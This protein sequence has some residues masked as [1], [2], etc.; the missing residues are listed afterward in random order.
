MITYRFDVDGAKEQF[1]VAF[2]GRAETLLREYPCFAGADSERIREIMSADLSA[3]RSEIAEICGDDRLASLEVKRKKLQSIIGELAEDESAFEPGTDASFKL[4]E[5]RGELIE[6]KKQIEKIKDS[7][8]ADVQDRLL[9]TLVTPEIMADKAVL[10]SVPDA[11]VIFRIKLA[12]ILSEIHTEINEAKQPFVG[13]E[14][15][16]IAK[17]NELARRINEA[18]QQY[19]ELSED[20]GVLE[21]EELNGMLKQ[22][23]GR[24]FRDFGIVREYDSGDMEMAFAI[25]REEWNRLESDFKR[26]KQED[27]RRI[28]VLKEI[29]KY[30][31][32]PDILEE[33]RQAY[34]RDLYNNVNVFG[35]TCTSRDRFTKSQLSDLERYP[36]IR[37][38]MA[39][40]TK[41]AKQ[42]ISKLEDYIGD[43]T[44]D[45]LITALASIQ[46]LF[47]VFGANGILGSTELRVKYERPPIETAKKI[48]DHVKLI[49][50]VVNASSVKQ[51][52]AYTGNSLHSLYEFLRD[53][54]TI[55][56]KAEQEESK[57]KRDL[58]NIRGV[59]G[60]DEFADAV[61]TDLA[62]LYEQL[63]KMEVCNNASN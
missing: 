61:K 24:F 45:N 58:Q 28:P 22:K 41:E 17:D 31:D 18:K 5:K 63:E 39:A 55:V 21:Q 48:A 56:L 37:K 8:G 50:N 44:Q 54:Q 40:D 29:C 51:L 27:A 25:I 16:A 43:L 3:I 26:T 60:L 34:T 32:S 13:Q 36:S 46:E 42:V 33:D 1:L 6:V 59:S 62:E 47:S 9:S 38:A 19:E 20:S 52:T 35:I 23:I 7:G 2:K 15:N 53:V 11:V 4:K 14:E 12:E 57:A 10:Q 49:S 30:L